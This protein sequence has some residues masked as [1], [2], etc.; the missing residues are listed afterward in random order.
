M[1]VRLLMAVLTL[2][3]VIPV[4]ICTCDHDHH[5][6][7]HFHFFSSQ[8]TPPPRGM[9]TSG[10]TPAIGTP[11]SDDSQNDCCDCKPRPSMPVA[12][13]VPVQTN[14]SDDLFAIAL[15]A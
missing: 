7:H 15:P 1:V 13:P 10:A 6:N 9:T 3:G 14:A 12:T 8:S 11:A 5:H 4:R 2:F